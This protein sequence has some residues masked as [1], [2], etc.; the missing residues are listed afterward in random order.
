MICLAKGVCSGNQPPI[1]LPAAPSIDEA[2]WSSMYEVVA[3]FD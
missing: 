3:V 2:V 1:N